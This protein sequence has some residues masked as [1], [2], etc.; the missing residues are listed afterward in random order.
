VGHFPVLNCPT[1]GCGLALFA[2]RFMC[3]ACWAMLTPDLR[4]AVAETWPRR[5]LF[6]PSC[7]AVE[8]RMRA[9]T[10]VYQTKQ[11]RLRDLRPSERGV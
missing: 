8:A 7:E 4:R 10:A 3:D 5:G 11:E 6:P 9:V 2:G 1:Q